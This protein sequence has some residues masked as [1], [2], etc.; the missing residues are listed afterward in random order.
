M[1]T[2]VLG[3]PPLTWKI[4]LE[5]FSLWEI[6]LLLQIIGHIHFLCFWWGCFRPLS[7]WPLWEIFWVNNCTCNSARL[8]EPPAEHYW[9]RGHFSDP[10]QIISKSNIAAR[11]AKRRFECFAEMHLLELLNLGKN[12]LKFE[13]WGSVTGQGQ[14]RDLAWV[15]SHLAQLRGEYRVQFGHNTHEC[16]MKL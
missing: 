4:I 15:Y 9:L 12:T 8:T 7:A 3:R 6:E 2:L 10:P 11:R 16:M 13:I 1:A 5:H 14:V